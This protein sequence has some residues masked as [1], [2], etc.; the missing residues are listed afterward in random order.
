MAAQPL[1]QLDQD[2]IADQVTMAVV[3]RLE[4]VDIEHPHGLAGGVAHG[5]GTFQPH[6]GHPGPVGGGL[7]MLDV[8]QRFPAG[9]HLAEAGFGAVGDVGLHLA[10]GAAQM[11]GGGET[12]DRRH[13]LVDAQEA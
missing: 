10:Q 2:L 6:P 1:G 11:G 5:I 8:E 12:I 4:V 13:A 9:Q 3:D 7:A